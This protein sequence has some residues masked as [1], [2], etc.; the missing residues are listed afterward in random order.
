M[1]QSHWTKHHKIP[2]VARGFQS[3]LK[4]L[5]SLVRIMLMP[6]LPKFLAALAAFSIPSV[7]L[8]DLKVGDIA[9][10]FTTKASLAGKEFDFNLDSALKKGPVVL[11]FFPAAFTEGCTIEA[12]EFAE[13]TD[14]FVRQ[15][16]TLIGVT[17]GHIDRVQEF[18]VSE[19]RNKFAVAADP[20]AKIASRYRAKMFGPIG[21]SNRTSY[22]I[23]PDHRVAYV[24]SALAPDAHVAN[25]L[26]VVKRWK[27]TAHSG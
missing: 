9:P 8:A 4:G 15:G 5:Y 2:S 16:A 7:A 13:A 26:A 20:G 3:L 19:C 25:T 11:Y 24:Y 1:A 10:T 18:S 22:V 17:A 23:T 27:S 14:D 12:H 6:R 21:W